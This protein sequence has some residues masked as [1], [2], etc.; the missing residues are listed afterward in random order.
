MTLTELVDALDVAE[1]D[2]ASD[3]LSARIQAAP[4]VTL[5]D[6]I[7]ACRYVRAEVLAVGGDPVPLDILERIVAAGNRLKGV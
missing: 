5:A 2:A 4:V 3:A 1:S 6:L 7:A